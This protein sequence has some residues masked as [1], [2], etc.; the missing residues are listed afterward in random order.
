MKTRIQSYDGEGRP[1]SLRR[2]SA[3]RRRSAPSRAKTVRQVT[4]NK[5]RRC[6]IR[7]PYCSGRAE[8]VHE[9]WKRSA[10]GPHILTP[11]PQFNAFQFVP[12]CRLC[13]GWVEDAPVSAREQGWVWSYEEVA[14]L[15]PQHFLTGRFLVRGD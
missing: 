7:G 14:R 15:F 5:T 13:N 10:G 9:K 8:T 6:R 3:K 11:D 1:S 12:C 4:K 2:Q